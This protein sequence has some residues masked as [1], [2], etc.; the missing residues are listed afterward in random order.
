MEH[1]HGFAASESQYSIVGKPWEG[2]GLGFALP[3]S[4]YVIL[5]QPLQLIQSHITNQ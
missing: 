4:N 1:S 5:G 2:W 3:L